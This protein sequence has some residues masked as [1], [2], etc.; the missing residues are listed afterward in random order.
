MTEP[1]TVERIERALRFMA[2]VVTVPGWQIYLPIFERLERELA[3]AR[4]R[5]RA[6]ARAQRLAVKS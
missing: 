2:G 1:V 4:S 3:L 5:E 6:L